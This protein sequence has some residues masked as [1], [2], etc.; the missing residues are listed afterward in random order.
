MAIPD[1]QT[2]MLPLLQ[3]TADGNG[4]SSR[5]AII[6]LANTF[7][8]NDTELQERLPSGRQ[9]IFDNRVYWAVAHL[10]SAGLLKAPRRG[11]FHITERGRQ[12]L[13]SGTQRVD[14][15]YRLSPRMC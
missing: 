8:L 3:F 15:K 14:L 9:T 12:T 7:G 10:K 11:Y 13:A 1:F 4:H 2:V 6:A 5:E